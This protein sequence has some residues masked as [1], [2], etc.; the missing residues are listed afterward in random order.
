MRLSI[1]RFIIRAIVAIGLVMFVVLL[2]ASSHELFGQNNGAMLPWAWPAFPN[3]SGSGPAAN[4]FVCTT[5]T[6]TTTPLATYSEQTLTTANANPITLNAAGRPVSGGNE[7]R[8]FLQ[9]LSYRITVYAAGTGNTCNGTTVGTLIRQVD[10][11]YDLSLLFTLDYNPQI[12]DNVIHCAQYAGTTADAKITAAIAVV[13]ATGGTV[14]CR[15]LEGAQTISADP[16]ATVTKSILLQ[17]GAATYSSSVSLIVPS[18][19]TIQFAEGGSISMAAATTATIRGGIIAPNTTIFAGSGNVVIESSKAA[20][21]PQWFGGS[22]D[23]SIQAAIRAVHGGAITANVGSGGIVTVPTGIYTRSGGTW[24]TITIPDHVQLVGPLCNRGE[25]WG[26]T[27]RGA[28]LRNNDNVDTITGRTNGDET[29]SSSIR[30]LSFEG[31]G[32]QAAITLP[33]GTNNFQIRGNSFQ[34]QTQAIVINGTSYIIDISENFFNAQTTGSILSSNSTGTGGHSIWIHDN[35][36]RQGTAAATYAVQFQ[37]SDPTNNVHFENNIVDSWTLAN[38]LNIVNFNSSIRGC[39]IRG[40]WFEGS[41]TGSY[42]VRLN[43]SDGCTISNNEFTSYSNGINGIALTNSS[44]GYNRFSS[45]VGAAPLAINLDAASSGNRID[46]QTLGS[47]FA[48]ADASG[49]ATSATV[50]NVFVDNGGTVATV[51][52]LSSGTYTPT[53]TN[54]VN[55]TASTPRQAQWFRVGNVITVALTVDVQAT[56]TATITDMGISLP[57]AT[58][59]TNA[60][61]LA[62]T[63]AASELNEVASVQGDAANDRATAAWVV[64]TASN[65]SVYFHFTYL[66]QG[67]IGWSPLMWFVESLIGLLLRRKRL[68]IPLCCLCCLL[69]MSACHR[70]GQVQAPESFAMMLQKTEGV[71]CADITGYDSGNPPDCRLIYEAWSRGRRR[72]DRAFSPIH[73]FTMHDVSFLKPYTIMIP[74]KAYPVIPPWNVRGITFT[75]G[76]VLIDYSYEAVIEHETTHALGFL[77]GLPGWEHFCHGTPDDPFGEPGNISS[78]IE[79]LLR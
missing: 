31:T 9:A 10:N 70:P 43:A 76:G 8:I 4:G 46:R 3:A 42:A 50:S 41:G 52:Y 37:G 25:W 19:M 29:L 21:V 32:N 75:A 49:S 55:V 56:T 34:G 5:T 66:V 68:S 36:I 17:L 57:V 63:G 67:I 62:G 61:N 14:D 30:C 18:T 58:D 1:I 12:V 59:I 26:E 23:L 74:E 78:C 44:F 13:P 16:F 15:G 38:N 79:R 27:S 28:V 39:I 33:T 71:S 7:I 51:T 22:T 69:V 6:G 65:H 73:R 54:S 48:I 11:V 20:V 45:P 64:Q 60:W 24:A 77:L 2:M 47:P 35:W 53:I 40:N 72:I